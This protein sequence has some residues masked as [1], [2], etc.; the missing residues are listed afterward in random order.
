MFVVK[1]FRCSE[2][3]AWEKTQNYQLFALIAFL[4]LPSLQESAASFSLFSSRNSSTLSTARFD[5]ASVVVNSTISGVSSKVRQTPLLLQEHSSEKP[6]SQ[7]EK[8]FVNDG[9]ISKFEVRTGTHQASTRI[10]EISSPMKSGLAEPI[11]QIVSTTQEGQSVG[12]TLQT[13][14]RKVESAKSVEDLYRVQTTQLSN[15]F[16]TITDLSKVMMH[17]SSRQESKFGVFRTSLEKKGSRTST[18]SPRFI[19][20]AGQSVEPTNMVDSSTIYSSASSALSFRNKDPSRTI[21]PVLS[22]RVSTATTSD[23]SASLFTSNPHVES[24]MRRTYVSSIENGRSKVT[25]L[26]QEY[27]FTATGSR[28]STGF[29]TSRGPGLFTSS[30]GVELLTS[31]ESQRVSLTPNEKFPLMVSSTFRTSSPTSVSTT[32]SSLVIVPSSS[33]RISSSRAQVSTTSQTS[34]HVKISPSFTGPVKSRVSALSTMSTDILESHD[35][36]L[37]TATSVFYTRVKTASSFSFS[38]SVQSLSTNSV[39]SQDKG[40]LACKVRN[41]TCLCYNCEEALISVKIC[42]MD[43]IDIQHLQHGVIMNMANITVWGFYQKLKAVSSV[44]AEEVMKSCREN[45]SLCVNAKS[46]DDI[47]GKRKK[48]SLREVNLKNNPLLERVRTKREALRRDENPTKPNISRLDVIIYN[49]SSRIGQPS[50]VE[51]TFFVTMMSSSD[52]TNQTVAVDGKG[53]LEILRNKKHTLENKLNIS[54]DSFAASKKGNDT[55]ATPNTPMLLNSSGGNSNVT[56]R[57]SREGRHC[58]RLVRL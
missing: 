3:C 16:H 50:S 29:H 42:C 9:F 41:T 12:M 27:I 37:T 30:Q 17:T 36:F 43:L 5:G 34:F 52:G 38:T 33:T 1:A 53:L 6:S 25:F 58:T 47:S 35:K 46:G 2:L 44:I 15:L 45:P 51:T 39:P 55:P 4:C 57:S 48:R 54:I 31:T 7:T 28:C 40:A 11:A 14:N 10:A 13:E 49:I 18:M 24:K 22:T 8:T 32:T 26:S 20:F 19:F 21:S 56:P 23:T